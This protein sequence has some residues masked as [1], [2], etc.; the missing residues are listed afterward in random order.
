MRA[1]IPR[2]L[3][4]GRLI[5]AAMHVQHLRAVGTNDA[6]S[7]GL[8]T[9]GRKPCERRR[10]EP[11]RTRTRHATE[12]S[13]NRGL[14][15]G[16]PRKCRTCTSSFRRSGHCALAVKG[17]AHL[18]GQRT[19]ELRA[20]RF[21]DKLG[22]M[23]GRAPG[24]GFVLLFALTACGGRS[25]TSAGEVPAEV[26]TQNDQPC[27]GSTTPRT[28]FGDY[29]TGFAVAGDQVVIA[30]GDGIRR[31]PLAGGDS[32]LLASTSDPSGPVVLNGNAYFSTTARMLQV[33]PVTGGD[34][35][36]VLGTTAN[37]SADNVAVD[38]A[39]LY[40]GASGGV[41]FFRFT[42]PNQGEGLPFGSES[43]VDAIAVHDDHLYVAAQVFAPDGS[44][45]G[46]I[47]RQP[48]T[49]AG[50]LKSPIVETLVADIGRPWSLVAAD[51]GLY[52][53]EEIKNGYSTTVRLSHANLDGSEV[54]TILD[55]SGA[56]DLAIHA[57]RIYFTTGSG[58]SSISIK[59]GT[60][61]AIVSGQKSA[62]ALA[63]AGQ[64]LLWIDPAERALSD[65]TVP[66]VLTACI[67]Q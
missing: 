31:V 18:I 12:Y 63:I 14:L 28:L 1:R 59:G 43:I 52:W 8:D 54:K 39:S 26:P 30:A 10:T 21:G 29:E 64:N 32:V 48:K 27:A 53:R 11:T 58:I 45:S 46:A 40:F 49:A 34:A 23:V 7:A 33:V 22:H 4:A 15:F 2:E 67:P 44:T 62:G 6:R 9:S 60:P 19:R 55:N 47:L 37:L 36:P 41:G 3:K 38:D 51:S 17:H 20:P 5:P 61:T 42:P 16:L 57:E 65:P 56:G 50:I 24:Y 66:A 35:H 25:V 13:H